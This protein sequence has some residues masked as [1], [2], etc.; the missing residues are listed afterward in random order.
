MNEWPITISEKEIKL[1]KPIEINYTLFGLSIL[2]IS[3]ILL[4]I[5]RFRKS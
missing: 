4:G 2:G 5:Y 3:I 1:G